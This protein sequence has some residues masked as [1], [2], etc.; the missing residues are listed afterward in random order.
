[1]NRGTIAVSSCRMRKAVIVEN[2]ALRKG[3]RMRLFRGRKS[4]EFWRRFRRLCA[5]GE[6]CDEE[7]VLEGS[8]LRQLRE[9]AKRRFRRTNLL[10]SWVSCCPRYVTDLNIRCILRLR[11][12][13]R[14]CDPR[15]CLAR[16]RLSSARGLHQTCD[17]ELKLLLFERADGNLHWSCAWR[18]SEFLAYGTRNVPTLHSISAAYRP[19]LFN[20]YLARF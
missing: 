3:A 6:D 11:A 13:K 4:Q 15:R 17:D 19:A 10:E 1:M 18:Q 2:G 8:D 7:E 5:S 20:N 12:K 9:E 16:Y 14:R